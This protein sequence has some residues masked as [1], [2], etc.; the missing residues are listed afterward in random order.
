MAKY[1]ILIPNFFPTPLNKL[2]C[3]W[4]V[5]AKYKKKDRQMIAAYGAMHKVPKAT[6][7]RRVTLRIYLQKRQRAWDPDALW[8]STLDALVHAGLLTNDNKEGC[9]LAPVEYCRLNN[10]AHKTETMI[11]L[12]DI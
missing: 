12:E 4:A 7:K 9:E 8:K 6:R 1:S 10:E 5:A 3:H 2:L 11:I